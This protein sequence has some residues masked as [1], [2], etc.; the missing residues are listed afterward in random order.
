M[1]QYGD[2]SPSS[3]EVVVTE[4]GLPMPGRYLATRR[5][6]GALYVRISLASGPTRK[7]LRPSK[8]K[9]QGEQHE[10]LID[11]Y[12]DLRKANV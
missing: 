9:F 1:R 12:T 3:D 10:V 7:W 2:V 4:Y 5:K 8:V 11:K 6:D